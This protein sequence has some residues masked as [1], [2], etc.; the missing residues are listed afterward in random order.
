[1]LRAAAVSAGLGDS[2]GSRRVDG[3]FVLRCSE[4]NWR[5]PRLVSTVCFGDQ[6]STVDFHGS[7]VEFW[8]TPRFCFHGWFLP[9]VLAIKEKQQERKKYIKDDFLEASSKQKRKRRK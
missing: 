9:L 8:R 6:S 1:M 5:T 2:S 3:T 7:T 4:L